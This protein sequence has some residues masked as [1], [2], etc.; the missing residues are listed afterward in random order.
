MK[1]MKMIT[2]KI[3][4]V[5]TVLTMLSL[6]TSCNDK[7][8]VTND[9]LYLRLEGT[10]A[11]AVTEEGTTQEYLVKS[12]GKWEIIRK[13][14]QT[15]AEAKPVFGQNDG[16]FRLTVGENK[17]YSD[18]SMR[19]A[20][21][22]NDKEL[23]EEGISIVQ[24]G[25][26]PDPDK[27][28]FRLEGI[29]E[30]AA[31]EEGRTQEYVVKSNGQWEI[32][33]KSE[34][35]WAEVDPVFGQND[36]TFRL[37][38][39]ENRSG[40]DRS[41]HL[42]FLLNGEEL[43]EES[44]LIFQKGTA[45]RIRID[46]FNLER[47]DDNRIRMTVAASGDNFRSL[48]IRLELLTSGTKQPPGFYTTGEGY[49][50]LNASLGSGGNS[51]FSLDH[52]LNESENPGEFVYTFNT[53]GW[54]EGRYMVNVDAHNRPSSGTYEWDRR[55]F[56]IDA[57]TPIPVIV[58]NIPS[59]NHQL[60]YSQKDVY[61][62]WPSFSPMDGGRLGL[63]F[64]TKATSTHIDNTGSGSKK[65]L[66]MD[67]GQSWVETT[68]PL[69]LPLW[70]RADGNMVVADAQGW[71]YAPISEEAR[72]IAE[73]RHPQRS[74]DTQVAYLGSP[75]MAVSKDNGRTWERTVLPRPEIMCGVNVYRPLATHIRTSGGVRITAM[76]GNRYF[77]GDPTRLRPYE[78]FFVRSDDDGYHWETRPMLPEGLAVALDETALV[79][80][81]GGKILAL[82]RGSRGLW[83]SESLDGGL[84]WSVPVETPMK[85][86][87][88]HVIR[89]KDGRLLCAYGMRDLYPMGIRAAI[90]ADEGKTWDIE[91]ELIIRGDALGDPGDW[92][93]P[94]LYQRP[95]GTILCSYYLTTD[96]SF[97]SIWITTFTL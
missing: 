90:S 88:A 27:P 86:Y 33:R 31:P 55:V 92:G 56:Y 13:S 59:A 89:L 34:D 24:K 35:S 47:L 4:N 12:N 49:I 72:L 79:E 19:F 85:G 67:E 42:N 63:S 94:I 60:I 15:W 16:S 69:Y 2:K 65:M 53:T 76:Y 52:P 62:A 10:A 18:R 17:S 96:G 87:P 78:V 91:N 25:A 83:Q 54:A 61:A 1:I 75:Y 39:E 21:L 64:S 74:S 9:S 46:H 6:S 7:K 81:S 32:I 84:S 66:S 71:I 44:I 68:E 38:V 57:G 3:R 29:T 28:Y 40:S 51:N 8:V 48:S 20:F 5:V 37:T 11:L 97:P 50:Y 14:V 30:L 26:I 58:S 82:S 93:Y 23:P 41:M 73:H 70:R 80:V 22:L 36:G 77:P 95:D 45:R 43:P